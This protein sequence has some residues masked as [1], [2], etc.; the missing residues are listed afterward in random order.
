MQN[1]VIEEF[2][3]SNENKDCSFSANFN[4]TSIDNPQNK[5]ISITRLKVPSSRLAVWKLLP[6]EQSDYWI[7]MK[8]PSSHTDAINNVIDSGEIQLPLMDLY[9]QSSVIE[10]LNRM[11]YRS[12]EEAMNT[13]VSSNSTQTLTW[14]TSGAATGSNTITISGLQ[15]KISFVKVELTTNSITGLH[16]TRLY[17]THVDSGKKLLLSSYSEFNTAQTCTFREGSYYTHNN[18]V[19]VTNYKPEDSFLDLKGLTPN[20]D[21]TLSYEADGVIDYNFSANLTVGSSSNLSSAPFLLL[22]SNN[23]LSFN[24]EGYYKEFN[25]QLQFSSKL[26]K[27]LGFHDHMKYSSASYFTY[28]YNTQIMDHSDLSAILSHTQS[29]SSYYQLS[30]LDKIL[31]L[32]STLQTRGDINLSEN[33]EN[34]LSDFTVDT[35][36]PF[37]NLTFSISHNPFRKYQLLNESDI[38]HMDLQIYA[39]YKN[40]HKVLMQYEPSENVFLRLTLF[41]TRQN[42][43]II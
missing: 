36:I 15:S 25:I 43:T 26:Q 9:S 19:G 30:N 17:L 5:K 8:I 13:L 21:W 34:V 7:R 24:Y 22:N 37:T 27:M 11:L 10:V 2:N 41:D 33:T 16:P 42:P 29:V 20:S 23:Y 18:E 28:L 14:N 39:Q 3:N 35:S 32:S 12:Y 31:I 4:R 1:L 6:D 38:R 40:K